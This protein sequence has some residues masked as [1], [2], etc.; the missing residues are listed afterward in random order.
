VPLGAVGAPLDPG[1]LARIELPRAVLEPSGTI[2]A[3]VVYVDG[4]GNV[5]LS[6]THADLAGSA[7]RLGHGAVLELAGG[8]REPVRVLRTFAEA[9]EGELLVYED[10]E[11]RLAVA[12]TRGS[13]AER[14]G[15]AAGDE[16]V[17]LPDG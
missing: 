10:A 6:V 5:Q 16:L 1:E 9:A 8:R 4:Y 11:R 14:L 13:A 15:L 7:L 12:V 3:H 17:I 2:R